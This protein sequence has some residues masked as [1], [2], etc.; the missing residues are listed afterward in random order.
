M[1]F[2]CFNV[3]IEEIQ[4]HNA[5][6]SLKSTE[7]PFWDHKHL[8]TADELV[9]QQSCDNLAEARKCLRGVKAAIKAAGLDGRKKPKAKKRPAQQTDLP[10]K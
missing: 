4:H 3:P 6:G 8:H 7:G 9:E 1:C 10:D 5:D 2:G